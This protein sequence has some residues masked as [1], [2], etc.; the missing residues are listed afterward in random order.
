M[1]TLSISRVKGFTLLELL[2]VIAIFA[3]LTSIALP[4]YDHHIRKAQRTEGQRLLMEIASQLER[5]YMAHHEYPTGLAGLRIYDANTVES[6]NGYY[7]AKLASASQAC[8]AEYCFEL[9]AQHKSQ[10]TQEALTLHSSG[11]RGGPW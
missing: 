2:I 7:S 11:E 8:P 10:S 5:Y 1:K 9:S 6:E 3:I 4:A